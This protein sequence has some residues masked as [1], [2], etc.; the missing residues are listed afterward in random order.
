ML[1]LFATGFRTFVPSIQSNSLMV[2]PL[3]FWYPFDTKPVIAFLGAFLCQVT[4]G[5]ICVLAHL[6]LDTM[7]FKL[8]S[9]IMCHMK[10]LE[11]RFIK[12]TSD[13]NGDVIDDQS[14]IFDKLSE[15]IENLKKLYW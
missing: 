6:L 8:T 15:N 1:T 9:Q 11:N 14:A 12:V 3:N 5:T 7:Y 4:F 13:E 2:L 10:I